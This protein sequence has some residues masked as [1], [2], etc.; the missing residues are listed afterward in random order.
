MK[1]MTDE[2]FINRLAQ[3]AEKVDYTHYHIQGDEL[4]LLDSEYNVIYTEEY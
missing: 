4:Q 2:Q 3:L 1:N